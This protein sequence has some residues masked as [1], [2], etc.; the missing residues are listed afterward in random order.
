MLPCDVSMWL[1][2]NLIITI[3]HEKG[4]CWWLA[5]PSTK[6]YSQSCQSLV[7]LGLGQSISDPHWGWLGARLPRDHRLPRQGQRLGPSMAQH[8]PLLVQE[9]QARPA[10]SRA[11]CIMD[12]AQ[13]QDVPISGHGPGDWEKHFFRENW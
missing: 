4:L 6:I 7:E 5:E 8:K 9:L 12:V 13:C 2:M 10:A 11:S 3:N 1:D